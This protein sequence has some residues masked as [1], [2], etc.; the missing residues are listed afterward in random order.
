MALM[1]LE[2]A[3]M[4]IIAVANSDNYCPTRQKLFIAYGG[5]NLGPVVFVLPWEMHKGKTLDQGISLVLEQQRGTMSAPPGAQ[6]ELD[7]LASKPLCGKP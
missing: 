6:S 4:T 3:H 7:V 1:H 2:Y 5:S